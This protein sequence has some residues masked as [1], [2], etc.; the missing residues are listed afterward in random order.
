MELGNDEKKSH[1]KNQR[2]SVHLKWRIISSMLFA[3]KKG[4]LSKEKSAVGGTRGPS[5]HWLKIIEG[6]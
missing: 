2:M 5:N 6:G 1:T 4:R 3:Q